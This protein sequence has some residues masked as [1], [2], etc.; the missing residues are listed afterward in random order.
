MG[1]AADDAYEAAERLEYDLQMF[2]K[3][4]QD[5][6]EYSVLGRKPCHIIQN[7]VPEYEEFYDPL[8]ALPYRC[9]HCGKEFDYP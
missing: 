9:R 7:E 4:I 6:C 8:E 2:M 3:A 5:S 1:D